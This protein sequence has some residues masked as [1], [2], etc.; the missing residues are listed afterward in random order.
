MKNK[1]PKP[2]KCNHQGIKIRQPTGY[3]FTIEIV[4]IICKN[5]KEIIKTEHC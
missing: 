3:I 2:N 5:C 4:E 1:K